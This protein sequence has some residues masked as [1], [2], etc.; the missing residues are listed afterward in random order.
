MRENH[1]R[2]RHSLALLTTQESTTQLCFIEHEIS[3]Y[4][5]V[6]YTSASKTLK[7]HEHLI[8]R[9]NSA[10]IIDLISFISHCTTEPPQITN[11]SCQ[12]R[13]TRMHLVRSLYSQ[14]HILL[15]GLSSPLCENVV[16][17]TESQFVP[18]V[19]QL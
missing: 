8:Y 7:E 9:T 2:I 4:E 10:K 3:S 1:P 15:L 12:L 19:R 6:F 11:I 17:W 13:V 16:N 18:L 14:S 5:N